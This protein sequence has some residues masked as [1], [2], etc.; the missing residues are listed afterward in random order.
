MSQQDFWEKFNEGKLERRTFVKAASLLGGAAVFGLPL[1]GCQPAAPKQTYEIKLAMPSAMVQEANL[2]SANAR[3]MFFSQE[4]IT[5]ELTEFSGGGDQVRAVLTGGFPIAITSPTAG[6]TALDQGQPARYIAGGFNASG[7]GFI[8]R[9]DSPFKKADDLK[10]KKFKLGYS[11]PAS[12]SHIVAYLGLKA[13]GVDP[14]DKNQVEFVATGGIPET[15]TAVKTGM[16]DV[17]WCSEPSISNILASK[18]GRLLWMTWDLVKEWVDVGLLTS[19]SFIDSNASLLKSWVSAY[20][21]SLDWVKNN[22]SEA[23]KD[24]A[25]YMKI[26]PAI[27]E[28]ALNKI[29]K[30][31]WNAS[32][33]KSYMDLMAK[34]SIEF[35]LLNN[36]PDWKVLINQSF[37]PENLR[38]SSY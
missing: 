16:I 6:M 7:Q 15:W 9:D 14:N 27:A 22:Y 34:A 2:Y 1:L 24:L 12:N 36:M 35:K 30:N 18:E 38:D 3:N 33:P 25:A 37:L 32:M 26:D 28:A 20:I 29:P 17:G 31:V 21:K 11:R 13:I 8:V 23:A 10:G 19:Q 4:G 5:N